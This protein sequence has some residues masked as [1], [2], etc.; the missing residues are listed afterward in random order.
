M[1]IL[2]TM[3]RT[4]TYYMTNPSSGQGERPT[5]KKKK[6]RNCLVYN[7]NLVASPGRAQRQ[8]GLADR[9]LQTLT[10]TR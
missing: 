2:Q 7:Q 4:V 1:Y 5:T 3:R 9:Q 10:L 6:K 8:N